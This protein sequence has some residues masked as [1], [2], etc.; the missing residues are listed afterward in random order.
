MDEFK[1]KDRI[2]IDSSDSTEPDIHFLNEMVGIYL[3]KA[4]DEESVVRL[5]FK[6]HE[7]SLT[8]TVNNKYIEPLSDEEFEEETI[9]KDLAK[10]IKK[11]N[12]EKDREENFITKLQEKL[13]I[14]DDEKFFLNN[15]LPCK[16]Y[17]KNRELRLINKDTNKVFEDENLRN[18]VFYGLATGTIEPIIEKIT[19]VPELNDKYYYWDTHFAEDDEDQDYPVVNFDFWR[20]SINDYMCYYTGNCFASR[21]ACAKNYSVIQRLKNRVLQSN[22]DKL[23]VGPDEITVLS[24]G[25]IKH[26]VVQFMM[27]IGLYVLECGKDENGKPKYFG[28]LDREFCDKTPDQGYT[29]MDDLPINQYNENGDPKTE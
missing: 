25:P 26:K 12:R 23:I 7:T 11:Y 28:V 15:D 19:R 27:P 2:K 24:S 18:K 22:M 8:M 29:T 17:F 16:C 14:E 5:N 9:K 4:N 6:E 20:G 1:Y 3:R 21:E 13:G 10:D